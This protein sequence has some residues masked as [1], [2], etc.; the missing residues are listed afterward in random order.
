MR[1]REN[2]FCTTCQPL[3]FRTTESEGTAA[4]L[5]IP[6]KSY[7]HASFPCHSYSPSEKH[8][9]TMDQLP[10]HERY[11]DTTKTVCVPRASS[12]Q[13]TSATDPAHALL[14]LS[15][16]CPAFVRTAPCALLVACLT[17][18]HACRPVAVKPRL[19]LCVCAGAGATNNTTL[20]S[21]RAWLQAYHA[22]GPH[23]SHI[24]PTVSFF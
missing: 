6:V 2:K 15:L 14:P 12:K 1:D 10:V 16:S 24:L 20:L 4:V 23:R 21:A 22:W 7:T 13:G 11:T 9:P 5:A 19:W 18:S 8:K 17:W 3:F